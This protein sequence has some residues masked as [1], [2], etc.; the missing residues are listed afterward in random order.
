MKIESDSSNERLEEIIRQQ[1]H[2]V[3]ASAQLEGD[4]D[5]RVDFPGASQGDDQ[6]SHSGREPEIWPTMLGTLASAMATR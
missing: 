6:R 5:Q 1:R 2:L 4:P 3:P